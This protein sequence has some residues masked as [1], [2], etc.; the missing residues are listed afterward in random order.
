MGEM[1][2]VTL[3]GESLEQLVTKAQHGDRAA[4]DLLVREH[5]PWVR[6]VIYAVTGHAEFVDDVAQ[7]VW[8]R[9]WERLPGLDDPRRLRAWLYTIAR[10]AAIDHGMAE[11]RQQTW[12]TPL[13]EDAVP[14]ARGERGPVRAA[15]EAEMQET[16]RS[17][18]R[19]LPVIYR[20]PF[21]LRHLED[22]SY[23]EIGEMLGLSV[24]TVET[25]LVR[26]RH[27]L[28]EMLRGKVE[29]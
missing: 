2:T 29:P 24:D 8:A 10:H 28:R 23:A 12:A 19:S 26:A 6:S 4:A 25:R 22:W 16:L 21:V 11:R 9:V 14:A 27:L 15:T 5:E 3:D 1:T 13:D 7:Q 20:E 17:A 18:V